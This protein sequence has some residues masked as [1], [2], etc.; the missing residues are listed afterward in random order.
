MIS[1]VLIEMAAQPV[2]IGTTTYDLQ[3]NNSSRNVIRA[4]PDG[5][6]SA[7]WIGSFDLSTFPD[8]GTFYNSFN[9]VSWG[10]APATREETVRTGFGEL[11]TIGSKEII[12]SHDGSNKLQV[13]KNTAIGS[14]SF[15]ET[16]GSDQI[17]GLWP[18]TF[19]PE[20]TDDIYVVNPNAST[21]TAI[22]FSRSM[23]GGNTWAVLNA[24]LPF[25]NA[26][27]GIRLTANATQ[28]EVFENDVYI[29]YGMH[30]SDLV[31]LH[32][33]MKGNP[34]TWTK[35]TLIDFPINNF[36]GA[37]GQST[38]YD[39]DGD[40][41]TILTHDGYLNMIVTDDG[42][43][44]FWTGVMRVVDT[45]PEVEGYNYFPLTSGMWYW[46]SIAD[47]MRII[48]PIFD[49]NNDDGLNDPFA[50]IG[51][52]RDWYGI[53][54][55]TSMAAGAYD[56]LNN[57]LYTVFAMPI[58][59]SDYFDDPTISEASSFRDFFGIYSD[60][61]GI[62]WSDPVAL[63]NTAL[64][65]GENAFPM[66]F[67]KIVNG[68]MHVVWEYDNDPGTSF[69]DYGQPPHTNTI[70]YQAFSAADFGDTTPVCD[71]ITPPVGL[72][73]SPVGTTTAVLHWDAI[74][75]AEKYQVQYF[76][77]AT[78]GTKLKKKSFTNSVNIT[79]LTPG[80]TYNFKVKTICPGGFMSPFSPASFFTT[81]FREG[82]AA[83][84]IIMYP[85]PTSAQVT[86]VADK[87]SGEKVEINV[88]NSMGQPVLNQNL[89]L[90]ENNGEIVVDVH[91]L[92]K[93]FYI[94]EI[95]HGNTKDS[96]KLFI[97]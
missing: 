36:T 28:I 79:G 17:I 4:Y 55:F 89:V 73:A 43:L 22:N 87:W 71:I 29:L 95:Q 8:R 62:T 63:T 84:H 65:F 7:A 96:G 26:A 27:E 75:L 37:I 80:A 64:S 34:G 45:R 74:P 32:S 25:L 91:N 97:E 1:L 24:P 77:V 67:P 59:Y 2:A 10:P 6:V 39:G 61:N 31:L 86:I 51:K 72:Y 3:T 18:N 78:P 48:D 93:G 52:N 53:L 50:G 92:P 41:D 47:T 21:P 88:I 56:E 58:E 42:I 49:A 83:V 35:Q 15:T 19:C 33:P 20:G 38:D 11:L 9:G 68:K 81:L 13:F 40:F 76:N 57:R 5:K 85:N 70:K 60:D 90:E 44:H 82:D 14:S 94:V 23:D 16:P 54:G 66:A 69:D 12:I 30:V 46:N